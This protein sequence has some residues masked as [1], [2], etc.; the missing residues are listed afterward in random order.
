[1]MVGVVILY[2]PDT[3]VVDRI[4]TYVDFLDSLYVCDNSET[5]DQNIVE[6]I[7]K[8]T[9]TIYIQDGENKGIS[10]RLNQVAQYT[11][12]K[13]FEWLLTMDQDS[14]FEQ[15]VLDQYFKC[16]KSFKGS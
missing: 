13:D 2:F 10:A 5:P 9:N 1:M 16:I 11:L 14:Y 12:E 3:K 8:K 15:G 4:N 7:K 6:R